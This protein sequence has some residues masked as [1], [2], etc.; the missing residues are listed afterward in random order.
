MWVTTIDIGY[1][2]R[3]VSRFYEELSLLTSIL[4][5]FKKEKTHTGLKCYVFSLENM[6]IMWV[7]SVEAAEGRTAHNNIWNGANGIKHLET[8]Y[9][10]YLIEF[11]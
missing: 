5:S 3:F 6:L 1:C 7:M 4:D 8:M 11:L 9:L 2:S 10:V